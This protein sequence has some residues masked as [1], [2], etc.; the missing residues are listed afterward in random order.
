MHD[1]FDYMGCAVPAWLFFAHYELRTGPGKDQL[2]KIPDLHMDTLMPFWKLLQ[3]AMDRNRVTVALAIAVQAALL[4]V[5]RVNGQKRCMRVQVT[6]R[7]GFAKALKN[8]QAAI[9][10]LA[11]DTSKNTEGAKRNLKLME[12]WLNE[13]NKRATT[14][15]P[16]SGDDVRASR[17]RDQAMLQTPW[18]VGQQLI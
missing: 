7:A 5:I 18:V 15:P 12:W 9:E 2:I 14:A 11:G 10:L 6:A 4:S 3:N 17:Q 13:W 1:L 8:T 16:G